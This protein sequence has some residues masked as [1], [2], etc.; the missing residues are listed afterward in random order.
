MICK[1][2][3]RIWIEKRSVGYRGINAESPYRLKIS[4]GC[5]ARTR[6]KEKGEGKGISNHPSKGS[7]EEVKSGSRTG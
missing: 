5:G 7:T 3:E 2:N 1:T 6:V 4:V